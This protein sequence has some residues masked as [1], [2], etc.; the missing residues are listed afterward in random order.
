MSG[1]GNLRA[2]LDSTRQK[3]RPSS[4]ITPSNDPNPIPRRRINYDIGDMTTQ[5]ATSGVLSPSANGEIMVEEGLIMNDKANPNDQEDQQDFAEDEWFIVSPFGLRCLDPTCTGRQ[6][7]ATERNIRD[8]LKS[9]KNVAFTNDQV[10]NV[11]K[12]VE[13]VARN[14]REMKSMDSYR[15]DENTYTCYT[16]MCGKIYPKKRSNAVAHC[17]TSANLCDPSKI[18]STSAIRLQCGRYVTDSQVEAFL[19]AP[20]FTTTNKFLD[21]K[22]IRATLK[23]FLPEKEKYDDSYTTMFFALFQGCP[24]F[25]AKIKQDFLDIHMDPDPVMEPTLLL[26]LAQAEEWLLKYSKKYPLLLPGHVRAALQSF[27]GLEVNEISQKTTYT[28]Q[29]DPSSILPTLK[30]LLAFAY[31][32]HLFT[33]RGGFDPDEDFY[34]ANFLKDLLLETTKSYHV[35]PFIVEFCL[36]SS[37]RVSKKEQKISMI[38]CDTVGSVFSQMISVCKAGVCSVMMQVTDD[39]RVYGP[40]LVKEIRGCDVLHTLCPMVRQLREMNGRIPNRRFTSVEEDSLRIVVEQ[41]SF[42]YNRWAT[43]VPTTVAMMETAVQS[44]ALGDWW[45]S[46][47]DMTKSVTVLTCPKT[48]DLTLLGV[49]AKWK[50]VNNLPLEAIDNLTAL[51]EMAFHGFGGGS[52]RMTELKNPTMFFCVFHHQTI[53]Y[54]MISLKVYNHLSR[55]VR[56]IKRKLPPIVGRYFLL[57]RSMVQ[58]Y[59]DTLYHGSGRAVHHDANDPDD[60]NDVVDPEYE[61]QE[62]QESGH[63]DDDEDNVDV[64]AASCDRM[65]PSRINRVRS[66][67]GKFGPANLMKEIF[68]LDGNPHMTQIRQFWASVLNIISSSIFDDGGDDGDDVDARLTADQ[69]GSEMMGHS[70]ATHK[71]KYSNLKLGSK[72]QEAHFNRY[73]LA[74]GDTSHAAVQDKETLSCVHLQVAVRHRHGQEYQSVAQ[75]ELVEARY[76][77]PTSPTH[78]LGL[79]AP[80]EGKSEVYILPTL[81]RI[82]MNLLS[83]TIVYVAPYNFLTGYQSANAL[84]AFEKLGLEDRVSILTFTGSDIQ[85]DKLPTELSNKDALPSLLFLSLD[86]LSNLVSFFPEDVKS[87]KDSVEMIV[88]DE[89]HTIF[90]EMDF[91]DKYSVYSKLSLLGIPIV[92][93][94]G[95]VPLFALDRL[96]TRLCW[97]V[98]ANQ[99]DM[100]IIHGGDVVGTFPL[101]FKIAFSIHDNCVEEVASFVRQRLEQG[102]SLLMGGAGATEAVHVFVSTKKEGHSLLQLLS[103]DYPN[104]CRFVSSE[105]GKDEVNQVAAE[106]GQSMFRVLIST[107]IAL[108]GNENP[109][110]RHLACAGYLFDMMSMVQF[111]GRLRPYMRTPS[112]QVFVCVPSKLPTFR[113]AE[114]QSRWTLLVNERLMRPRDYSKF[115]SAM[116]SVGLHEWV[117]D[118]IAGTSGCALKKLSTVMGNIRNDNCGACHSCRSAPI[119]VIQVVAQN[120]MEVNRDHESACQ[121]VLQRLEQRYLVGISFMLWLGEGYWDL[122]SRQEME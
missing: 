93:L 29:H 89:V 39:F 8:H 92:G 69:M 49:N 91:R 15:Y 42:E 70:A 4:L 41:H 34:V 51:M 60:D 113:Q 102:G 110:C 33:K 116:T 94:S 53:Y 119:R 40:S 14:A 120:R 17:K 118:S 12:R 63:H 86:A 78:C 43:I 56:H 9:H 114:D 105:T 115:K 76:R 58:W 1:G 88:V 55:K 106:W 71:L 36:M 19:N 22:T 112:G 38:S 10:V 18:C 25:V 104:Q 82:L 54:S 26:I 67:P 85:V 99:S 87:W 77:T 111:L 98:K 31:R 46:V 6:I 79:L 27:E 73:H 62:V 13:E 68:N 11:L 45:K 90:C 50:D 16:C 75:K 81:A 23:P 117:M 122:L 84:T 74:I 35:H 95:S 80:G 24:D 61:E 96:V 20:P 64:D 109:K 30:K 65:I 47:V 3:K 7:L 44:L 57:F 72:Q 2:L 100:K 83:K 59:S 103:C 97:S 52:A 101:G 121:R 107:S 32:R 37:F 28:M 21:L 108:V 5:L 48:A 66:G